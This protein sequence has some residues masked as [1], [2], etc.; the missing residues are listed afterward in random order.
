M[1]D[2][3]KTDTLKVDICCECWEELPECVPCKACHHFL[4]LKCLYK[5]YGLCSH[6]NEEDC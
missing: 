5:V 6:C 1:K 3:K 4:C 2:D